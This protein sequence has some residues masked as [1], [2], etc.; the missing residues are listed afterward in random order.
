MVN[1]WLRGMQ[2]TAA[3]RE[4]EHH[5]VAAFGGHDMPRVN[6]KITKPIA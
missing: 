6:R 1:E 5:D 4:G 2:S 3:A